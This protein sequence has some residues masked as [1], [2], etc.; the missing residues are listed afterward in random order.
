VVFDGA[1]NTFAADVQT[2]DERFYQL[3]SSGA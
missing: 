2:I 3:T 1:P